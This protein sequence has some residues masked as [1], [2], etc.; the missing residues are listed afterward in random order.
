MFSK[1]TDH[2]S[3]IG[4]TFLTEL[5]AKRLG[6]KGAQIFVVDMSTNPK[7]NGKTFNSVTNNQQNHI[8]K[9]TGLNSDQLF[10]QMQNVLIP[11]LKGFK[12]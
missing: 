7:D 4:D 8:I 1:T 3:Y 12:C 5:E 2:F 9:G 6:Q 10:A 11:T